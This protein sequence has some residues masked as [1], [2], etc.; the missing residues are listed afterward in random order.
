MKAICITNV[1]PGCD[2]VLASVKSCQNHA[3]R[4][5]RNGRCPV[6]QR[7]SRPYSFAIERV[8]YDDECVCKLCKVE[9][10]GK[11]NIRDHMAQHFQAL[12]QRA[13]PPR[14]FS[15]LSRLQQWQPARRR[16]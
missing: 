15:E 13:P 2:Q 4:A 11:S 1:C 6:S 14:R 10:K 8:Q 3:V 7:V 9:L 12:L 5:M 16:R